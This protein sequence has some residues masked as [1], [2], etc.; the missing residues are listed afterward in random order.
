MPP[1]LLISI[2]TEEEFDWSAPMSPRQRAV[3]HVRHLSRLHEVFEETGTRPT[4]L[5]DHP[6]ATSDQGIDV[7]GIGGQRLL[8][9]DRRLFR[10]AE[11]H[12]P[13][14]LIAQAL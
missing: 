4:Y 6:I 13:D 2:D 3:T 11:L 9:L 12:Q 8:K 5:L 14:T 7:L 1:T 10:P